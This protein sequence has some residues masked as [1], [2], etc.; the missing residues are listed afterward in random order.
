M[1]LD[2]IDQILLRRCGD[3]LN[4]NVHIPPELALAIPIAGELSRLLYAAQNNE[5]SSALART[6]EKLAE[7]EQWHPLLTPCG[8]SWQETANPR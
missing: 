3:A 2:I 7:Y 8:E 5:P 1:S 4:G 6:L